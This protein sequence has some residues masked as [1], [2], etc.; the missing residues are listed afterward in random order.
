MKE[1]LSTIFYHYKGDQPFF[2]ELIVCG[3][4]MHNRNSGIFNAEPF[5]YGY[6]TTPLCS[7]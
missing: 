6:G 5:Y 7:P 3:Q 2:E 1:V 4:Y